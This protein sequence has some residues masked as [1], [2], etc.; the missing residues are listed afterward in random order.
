MV[1]P[2][3]P[4]PT[5]H[6]FLFLVQRSTQDSIHSLNQH[7][8]AGALPGPGSVP[9]TANIK[10]N[11]AEAS[12][13]GTH[14]PVPG[15]HVPKPT[16]KKGAARLGELLRRGQGGDV[17]LSSSFSA[18]PRSENIF[19]RLPSGP[20]AKPQCSGT[21]SRRFLLC[22]SRLTTPG[23][24]PPIQKSLPNTRLGQPLSPCHCHLGVEL[25][26]QAD[27]LVIPPNA[28]YPHLVAAY[29]AQ[30]ER[31]EGS[32]K[33]DSPLSLP[34]PTRPSSKSC[35][36]HLQDRAMQRFLGCDARGTGSRRKK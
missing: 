13:P 8:L 29:Y 33:Q 2:G 19:R 16:P 20:R 3:H 18:T 36:P 28:R 24:S 11:R 30:A 4:T 9:G 25:A 21:G 34:T 31:L 1:L 7:P 5:P 6:T 14:N 27:H 23:L 32:P 22:S 15:T 26:P 12:D 35:R 17:Y 10:V